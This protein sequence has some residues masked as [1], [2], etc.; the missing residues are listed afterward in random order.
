MVANGLATQVIRD[1]VTALVTVPNNERFRWYLITI[2]ILAKK[3]LAEN[4][5]FGK[6][7]I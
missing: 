7:E 2:E 4:T 5:S 3:E 1:T 6:N